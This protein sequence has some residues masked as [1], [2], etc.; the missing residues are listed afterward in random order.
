MFKRSKNYIC[1]FLISSG[2]VRVFLKSGCHTDQRGTRDN[3]SMAA[4][5]SFAQPSKLA[6]SQLHF[7]SLYIYEISDSSLGVFVYVLRV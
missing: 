5:T 7:T 2:D 1:K 6:C 3:P 4:C